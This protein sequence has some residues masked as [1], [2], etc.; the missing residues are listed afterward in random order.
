MPYSFAIDLTL[1]FLLFIGAVTLS[2]PDIQSASGGAIW[3]DEVQCT[4]NETRLIDCPASNL[5][6]HDCTHDQD[7]GVRCRGAVWGGYKELFTQ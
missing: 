4:G 6:I 7:A 2:V 1:T 5:G 3:L